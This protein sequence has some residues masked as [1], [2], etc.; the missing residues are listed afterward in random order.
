MALSPI[1]KSVLLKEAV[2]GLNVKVGGRYVDATLGQAGHALEIIRR[3]G[4]AL[5]I[6]A[7][8]ETRQ[9]LDQ[10]VREPKLRVMAG[11]FR[12]I[13]KIVESAGWAIVDGIIFDLGLSTFELKGS[14]R[15]WSFVGNEPLD[16]RLD[17]MA[18]G[19]TAAD[20]LNQANPDELYEIFTK[21][22]E[23]RNSGRLLAALVHGRRLKKIKTTT[24]LVSL[25]ET[26][27]PPEATRSSLPQI[28]QALRIVVNE[29]LKSLE[30]A[31]KGGF[32]R[33]GP[34]GRLVVISFH[35]L[36]DRI[37]KKAFL[38]LERRGWGVSI[39][40]GRPGRRE[41][42]TNPSSRSAKLRI[43]EKGM[44]YG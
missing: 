37:V 22:G 7:N 1:H 17:P 9:W 30:I 20:I 4:E 26:A 27:F 3:G 11:N 25:V 35:S 19:A 33:L 24:D 31:L 32:G 12:D 38:D 18:K 41:I 44:V 39:G 21:F 36:E 10:N 43:F 40:P 5:G 14:G 16:M 2:D 8:P 23:I 15:G 42:L 34:G 29:E 6:E 13:G 28:F